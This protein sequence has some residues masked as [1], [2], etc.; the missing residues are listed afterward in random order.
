MLYMERINIPFSVHADV[1]FLPIYYLQAFKNHKNNNN[2]KSIHLSD[3]LKIA[4]ADCEGHI[5]IHNP[6]TILHKPGLIYM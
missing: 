2:K 4:P 3:Y 5:G 6:K 1:H